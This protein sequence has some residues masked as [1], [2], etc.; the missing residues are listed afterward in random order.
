MNDPTGGSPRKHIED[1]RSETPV[2]GGPILRRLD[3]WMMRLDRAVERLLPPRYNPF[4][5]TGAIALVT[6]LISAISGIFLLIWYRPSVHQAYESVLAME[7][8]VIGSF[9][10][11]LHRYASD[12]CIFFALIHALRLFFARRFTGARW[13]AWTSGIVLIGILWF[14]GWTGYMLIWDE[15]AQLIA[16]SSAAFVDVLPIFS[17]PISRSFLAEDLV[18]SLIFF[19]V[20][21]THMLLPLAIVAGIWV[22]VGRLQRPRLL[23]S[24]WMTLWIVA[25]LALLSLIVPA[26]A[27]NPTSLGIVPD[28][29]TIDIWYLA[30]LWLT[31]RLGAGMLWALAGIVGGLLLGAPWLLRRCDDEP[32]DV[33]PTTD[34]APASRHRKAS[35]RTEICNGCTLCARDCPYDAI[36]MVPR[37]DGRRYE[38]Q[39]E[40]RPDRCVGCG[41]CAGSCNPGGIGLNWLPIQAMRKRFDAWID[42]FVDDADGDEGPILAFLCADSAAAT[43]EV[44]EETGR[45]DE[46]P[47]YRVVAVPCSGWV[48]PLT[49]ERALRRG[50][51]G[52]LI[53]GCRG[54]EPKYREGD[55]W[56]ERRLAGSR[57]P[58]LRRDHVDLSRVEHV[59]FDR[60]QPHE[61]VHRA[62]SFRQR[63]TAGG[64]DSTAEDR[65]TTTPSTRRAVA[66]GIIIATASA[67]LI[68]LGSQ[69]PYPGP[70]ETEPELVVSIH[71][72]G[73]QIEECVPLSEEERADQPAHMQ[74]DEICERGRADVTV[75]IDVDG[76]TVHRKTHGPRGLAGGGPA[77]TLDRLS[78]EPGHRTLSIRIS[79]DGAPDTWQYDHQTTLDFAVDRR[80]VLLFDTGDGFQHFG[81]E[82]DG[83]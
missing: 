15:P 16:Q 59:R 42:E 57:K 45:C 83:E 17:E 62:R 74:R 63:V 34:D 47:G 61:L 66:G 18:P 2:R 20:F 51:A 14:I 13:L 53:V 58:A 12:A 22:H 23:T 71:H 43:F 6:F 54:S 36:V 19:V 44:D 72:Y 7:A 48:Q 27:Q 50:A 37:K 40:L 30:P 70:P 81:T 55:R 8:S 77:V 31:D 28:A 1:A 4:A 46:L 26:S 60:T 69:A 49:I 65:E 24:R 73:Q 67:G 29:M 11:S 78:V 64:P 3:E 32:D 25:T 33:S 10:R 5:Q 75:E 52:V 41:V 76:Q 79:D 68:G 21:F 82:S 9:V 80:E 38:L 39:A 35:I 56:T